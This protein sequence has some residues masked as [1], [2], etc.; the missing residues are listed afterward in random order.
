[1]LGTICSDYG[2]AV[3]DRLLANILALDTSS[4]FAFCAVSSADGQ[5]IE[6]R[7]K[8]AISH[9]EELSALVSSALEGAGVAPRQLVGIVVGSGPG[10]FT[11]LRIGY[12][13]AKGL[14]LA[15]RLPVVGLSSFKAAAQ[16]MA[17][18]AERVMVLADARREELFAAG[19]QRAGSMDLL[20]RFPPRIVPRAELEN[21]C[22]EVFGEPRVH[23]VC[24]T[25]LGMGPPLSPPESLA[26]GLLELLKVNDL[27]D[28]SPGAVAL[29]EPFYLRS[30]AARTI[31]ERKAG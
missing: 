27:L 28:F 16:A 8:G 9:N 17:S 10:S 30:V 29:L 21:L 20:E 31:I 24:E 2:T 7:S 26:R 6:R 1:M 13:F 4:S 19:Y 12:S 22:L 14:A 25:E 5:V 3:G 11:G 23:W 18:E 15:L